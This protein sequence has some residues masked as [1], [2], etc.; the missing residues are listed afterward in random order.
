MTKQNEN[1]KTILNLKKQIEQKKQELKASERFSPITNCSLELHGKRYNLHTL[2]EEEMVQLLVVLN[3]YKK[4]A[5]ELELVADYEL[6]GFSIYSWIADLKKRLAVI[7][8]NTEENRLKTLE[9]RLHN[10][11]T[12]ETKVE[13]EIDEIASSL[14]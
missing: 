5:E 4:S 3:S 9:K 10:L 12:I 11:L 14:K 6:S 8:R 1:D 13:L 7:N 2:T